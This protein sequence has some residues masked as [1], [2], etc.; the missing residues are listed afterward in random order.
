MQ[1]SNVHQEGVQSLS[2][3][4]VCPLTH[5]GF[6]AIAKTLEKTFINSRSVRVAFAVGKKLGDDQHGVSDRREEKPQ[7]Q[8]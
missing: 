7:A 8:A 2:N 6:A 4:R 1:L 3:E 5:R